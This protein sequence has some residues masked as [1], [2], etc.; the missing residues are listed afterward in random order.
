VAF[1]VAIWWPICQGTTIGSVSDALNYA[2]KRLD[3]AE[4]RLDLLEAG[5]GGIASSARPGGSSDSQ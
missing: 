3:A 1:L 4:R 5:Q 2:L